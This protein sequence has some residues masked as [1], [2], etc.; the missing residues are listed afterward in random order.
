MP[1]VGFEYIVII[2][3]DQYGFL[4]DP[5]PE[6]GI[7]LVLAGNG[8]QGAGQKKAYSRPLADLGLDLRNAAG[9]KP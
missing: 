4:A 7:A 1:R 5:A 9:L 3:D 6:V 8:F 2:I